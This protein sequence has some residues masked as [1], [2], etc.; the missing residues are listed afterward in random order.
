MRRSAGRILL[1][2]AFTLIA[3]CQQAPQAEFRTMPGRGNYAM[4]IPAGV[5]AD[6]MP[7]L[8]KAQ[9]GTK[10][11]C[12]VYGWRSTEDAASAIPMTDR[13]LASQIFAYNLNRETGFERSL[14]D[15]ALYPRSSS[16]DCL[17]AP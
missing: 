8:A 3:G 5:T 9:C 17:A 7:A 4:I 11:Q 12:S 15:C 14:W 2:T 10:S 1:L 13:E 6:A 16:S